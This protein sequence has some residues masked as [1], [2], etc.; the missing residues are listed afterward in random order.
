MTSLLENL[1]GGFVMLVIVSLLVITFG[2]LTDST[3]SGDEFGEPEPLSR[4]AN[5][6]LAF[7]NL[8]LLGLWAYSVNDLL[9]DE[10]PDWFLLITGAFIVVGCLLEAYRHAKEVVAG[11]RTVDS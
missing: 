3:R 2:F 5:A 9:A 1:S 7:F 6:G 11:N 10:N 8:V 4:S